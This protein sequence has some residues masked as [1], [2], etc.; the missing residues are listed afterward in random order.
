MHCLINSCSWDLFSS[1]VYCRAQHPD[2]FYPM[3]PPGKDQ[4][5]VLREVSCDASHA[6]GF[7]TPSCTHFVYFGFIFLDLSPDTIG[8]GGYIQ[9]PAWED[10]EKNLL[11][12][13]N[14]S[15]D[16]GQLLNRTVAPAVNSAFADPI[17]ASLYIVVRYKWVLWLCWSHVDD[18]WGSPYGWAAP[19]EGQ[20]HLAGTFC[21]I[22][23]HLI[24]EGFVHNGSAQLESPWMRD[25]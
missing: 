11:Q 9:L 24:S 3:T 25:H 15:G 2:Y 5:S 4:A 8:T 16:P 19:Y 6:A 18:G 20:A 21:N 14:S 10:A 23:P 12:W 13:F 1:M 22:W 17:A 7:W